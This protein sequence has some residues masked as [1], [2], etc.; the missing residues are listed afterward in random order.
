MVDGRAK[1]SRR[2]SAQRRAMR[3]PVLET[4][5]GLAGDRRRVDSP[6]L[7]ESEPGKGI[8]MTSLPSVCPEG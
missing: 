4:G 3:E 2:L 6:S 1:R 7:G 5:L 8:L